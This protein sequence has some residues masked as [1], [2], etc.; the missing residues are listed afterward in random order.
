MKAHW[1]VSLV[2]FAVIYS[3]VTSGVNFA[4]DSTFTLGA[5][6]I[7]T[8]VIV[9]GLVAAVIEYSVEATSVSA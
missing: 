3:S 1:K 7:S 2:G 8:L 4:F 9:K 6:S 5:G